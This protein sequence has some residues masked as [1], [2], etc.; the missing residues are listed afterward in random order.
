MVGEDQVDGGVVV[1]RSESLLTCF[2]SLVSLRMK[3]SSGFFCDDLGL[4]DAELVQM[5][6]V[7]EMFME[8]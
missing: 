5:A 8:R 1:H 2:S 4:K 6:M 3:V 7:V